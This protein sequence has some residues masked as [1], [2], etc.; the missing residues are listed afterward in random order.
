MITPN[1]ILNVIIVMNLFVNADVVIVEVHIG[2]LR[3]IMNLMTMS[4][5]TTPK[6]LM[7][8]TAEIVEI[9]HSLVV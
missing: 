7:S 6:S 9:M 3:V 8:V 1:S 5:Q 4:T 2:N